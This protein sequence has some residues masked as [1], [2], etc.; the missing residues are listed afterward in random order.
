MPN[1]V[2]I[3]GAGPAGLMLAGDL[4]ADGVKVLVLE[5]AARVADPP[6]P[7]GVHARTLEVLDRR[8]LLGAFRQRGRTQSHLLFAGTWPL[9]LDA[10]AGR[11]EHDDTPPPWAHGSPAR[12]RATPTGSTTTN[13]NAAPSRPGRYS[14]PG[15]RSTSCARN[16]RPPRCAP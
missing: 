5:R 10:R 15:P 8:G 6:M 16:R 12:W 14:S 1:D 11:P 2:I 4:A 13:G 9:R 7:R 3:A